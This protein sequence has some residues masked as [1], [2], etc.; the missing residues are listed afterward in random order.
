[1]ALISVVVPIYDVERY[2]SACLHSIARQTAGDL[3]VIMVDDGSRDGSAAIAREFARRDPRF[4][5]IAQANGGLGH[6]RNTGSDAARGDYLTFVDSDDVLPSDALERLAGSLEQTGSDFATGNVHRLTD[7]GTHQ[8][9]FLAKAF[10]RTRPR[11]HVTRHPA[12]LADRCAWNK[13]WRRSFWD[14]H[15]LRFPEGVLHEDIPVT[16]PA[17]VL[18]G[19]VDVI[20]APVYRYRIR[21]GEGERSITQR[22]LE[23]RTLIDRLAAVE[24][25]RAFLAGNAPARTRRR[26]DE[27]LVGDDLRLHLDVLLDADPWYRTLFLDRANAILDT[28]HGGVLDDLPALDRLKW[29]L[30]RAGREEELLEVLRF[31]RDERADARPVRHRG[32]WYGDY[33]FRGDDRVGI[34]ATTYR[35]ERSDPDLALTPHLDEL[36]REDGRLVLRGRAC[37]DALGAPEPGFQ[38]VALSAV[39]P[40]RLQ[41]VR[42]ALDP[43]RLATEAVRRDDVPEG[44]RDAWSGFEAVLD[45]RDLRVGG[46]WVEGTWQL[47]ASVRAGST[48]RRRSR[49]AVDDPRTARTV[50]LPAA[51]DVSVRA[52]ATPEGDLTVQVRRRWAA[53]RRHD[54]GRGNLMLGGVL[55]LPPADDHL[56][57]LR[58][59]SDGVV[60]TYPLVVQGWRAPAPFSAVV[61]LAAIR[62]AAPPRHGEEEEGYSVWELRVVAGG[63]RLAVELPDDVPAGVWPSA[64]GETALLRTRRG[65]AA[66]VEQ[67]VAVAPSRVS[68]PDREL[69]LP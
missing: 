40:G 4:R 63:A 31:Q 51:P 37:I 32:R 12:L 55:V 50:N 49:F 26:Y 41:R 44:G 11:T 48:W 60:L 38:R 69:A 27:R 24:H 19:A 35:L 21:E 66:L 3:E 10:A 14:A 33:P 67:R 56:L 2:L 45:P 52:T 13:L 16:L 43:V 17:H 1:M 8:A 61:D 30:V 36:R 28:A 34:P 15:G 23:H 62:G 54:A 57:E 46:R 9:P 22:R 47:S 39:R 42:R 29:R 64:V 59:V 5:L 7:A 65:D 20:A 53:V 25:V 18:A 6:A 68:E 58:R